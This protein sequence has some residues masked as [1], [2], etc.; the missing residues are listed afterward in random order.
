M[1]ENGESYERAHAVAVA[2]VLDGFGHPQPEA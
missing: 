2:A 1:M